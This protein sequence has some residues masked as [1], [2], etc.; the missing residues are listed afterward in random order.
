MNVANQS[1]THLPTWFLLNNFESL[2]DLCESVKFAQKILRPSMNVKLS[3]IPPRFL[4]HRTLTDPTAV[5]DS[6]EPTCVVW[7]KFVGS[8][9]MDRSIRLLLFWNYIKQMCY[10]MGLFNKEIFRGKSWL[11]SF[12]TSGPWGVPNGDAA[13]YNFPFQKQP[14][15][16]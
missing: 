3:F 1:V 4:L 11:H 13:A 14:K 10:I 16:Q 6:P 9:I 5:P 7:T 15:T 2:I 8:P 12:V